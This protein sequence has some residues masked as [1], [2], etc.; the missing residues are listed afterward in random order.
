MQKSNRL[1]WV[2]DKQNWTQ[3]QWDAIIFSDESKFDLTVGDQRSRVIRNK[4]EAFHPDCLKR[5]IK[6]PAS[7]MVWGCMSAKGVGILHF[8]D[9]TVN[10]ARYQTILSECLLPSL[11]KL[12]EFGE[13]VFQQDG[14]SCHTA[15]STKKWLQ[16]HNIP[17][18]QWPSGSPDLSPIESLWG[19][20][21]KRLRDH[22]QTTKEGLRLELQRIWDTEITPEMCKSLI[23]TMPSRI[24]AVKNAKGDVSQY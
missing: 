16:D 24:K 10:A 9:G 23:E 12:S 13:Y 5:S 17:T 18:L 11:E 6:F 19:I 1:K 14:A 2:K 8:I 15:K 21:K 20:M 7:L 3:R 4:N 22:P